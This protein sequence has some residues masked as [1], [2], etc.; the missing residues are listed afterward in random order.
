MTATEFLERIKNTEKQI[1]E[2]RQKIEWL[3]SV[4][5]GTTSNTSGDR[6]QASGSQ[7]RMADAVEECIDL[8]REIRQ[9][10]KRIQD[11]KREILHTIQ[12]LPSYYREFLKAV[13][14]DGSSFSA[15]ARAK[16]KSYSWATTTHQRAKDLLQIILNRKDGGD[17]GEGTTRTHDENRLLRV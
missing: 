13:Y 11:I 12:P 6:V 14:I 10:E 15:L 2:K 4:A 16:N 3:S 17:N 8:A 5:S 1:E 7:Q 9:L